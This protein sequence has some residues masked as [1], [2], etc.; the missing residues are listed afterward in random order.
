MEEKDYLSARKAHEIS[1]SASHI[2]E[3][4]DSIKSACQKGFYKVTFLELAD[5]DKALLQKLGYK[6]MTNQRFI[7]V[8][9]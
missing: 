4:M 2:D 3:V 6:I 8:R 7:E 5:A 9:W 1:A